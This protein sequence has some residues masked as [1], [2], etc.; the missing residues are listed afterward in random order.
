MEP[1]GWI[2]I[3]VVPLYL[4]IDVA[5]HVLGYRT[6]SQWTWSNKVRLA[7]ATFAIGTLFGHLITGA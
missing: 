5:L 4:T 1:A 7:V 2:T 6:I 3:T